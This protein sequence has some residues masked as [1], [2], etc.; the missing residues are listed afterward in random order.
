MILKKMKKITVLKE[1]ED[2]EKEN[3]SEEEMEK[4]EDKNFTEV[5]MPVVYEMLLIFVFAIESLATNIESVSSKKIS[6][7]TNWSMVLISKS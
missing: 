7:K 6:L 5:H 4:T 1:E 3:R 2:G